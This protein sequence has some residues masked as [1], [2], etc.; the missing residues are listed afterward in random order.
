[1]ISTKLNI[2]CLGS[3]LERF[4]AVLHGKYGKCAKLE[5]SQNGELSKLYRK[6]SHWFALYNWC[7]YNLS[8]PA[9]SKLI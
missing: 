3:V 9:S 6:M 1:M 7:S 4:D 2:D 5:Q 8:Y